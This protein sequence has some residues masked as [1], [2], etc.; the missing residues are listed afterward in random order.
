MSKVILPIKVAE[1]ID[2]FKSNGISNWTIASMADKRGVKSAGDE[3]KVL[4]AYVLHYG[5]D[6]LLDALVLGYEVVKTPE[7]EVFEYMCELARGKN[8]ASSIGAVLH[9]LNT[10]DI[11]IAGVNSGC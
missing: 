8:N 3:L 4:Q 6:K 1:A 9:V 2:Y 11:K 10:L 5:G 7:E